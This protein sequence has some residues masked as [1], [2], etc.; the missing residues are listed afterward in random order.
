MV[1]NSSTRNFIKNRRQTTGRALGFTKRKEGR[2]YG[3]VFHWGAGK[4]WRF[5][6]C[7]ISHYSISLFIA[8]LNHNP[9]STV[10]YAH[11]DFPPTAQYT[12][13]PESGYLVN[14]SGERLAEHKGLWYYTIG[15]R[16]R[17]ANQLKPMFVAK[18]GVGEKGT[19]ILVVPGS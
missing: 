17:V 13:P 18:K 15:Q 11:L 7:V 3:R 2:V 8:G 16:A 14:L 6:L 5:H 1:G 12:S 9:P 19:D 4:V 10:Y